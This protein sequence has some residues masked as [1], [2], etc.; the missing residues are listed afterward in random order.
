MSDQN[1]MARLEF[2]QEMIS[3]I[4]KI[5]ERHGTIDETLDDFE[6]HH[7]VL[8]CLFQIGEALNKIKS[9]EVRENLPVALAYTMRNIIA[10]DYIGVNK[11]VINQTVTDDIPVLKETI[12][13]I[14]M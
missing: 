2:I 3:D 5:I 13:R 14:L 4:E 1:D 6:G 11:R 12:K 10:H 8:M 9:V 7:A